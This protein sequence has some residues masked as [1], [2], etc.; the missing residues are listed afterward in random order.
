MIGNLRVVLDIASSFLS[1]QS[2]N[3]NCILRSQIEKGIIWDYAYNISSDQH[4][5]GSLAEKILQP[6]PQPGSFACYGT[7]ILLRLNHFHAWLMELSDQEPPL[8]NISTVD[9]LYA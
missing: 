7:R 2:T 9:A 6:S 5:P 1:L 3:N 4:L 8:K